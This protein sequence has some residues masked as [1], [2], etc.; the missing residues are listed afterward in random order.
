MDLGR[1]CGR[2]AYDHRTN[3]LNYGQH[4]TT[5]RLSKLHFVSI[6]HRANVFGTT[7]VPTNMPLAPA[8]ATNSISS[9]LA[10]QDR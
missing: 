3:P 4:T 2:A 6:V 8:H 7:T 9:P 10:N 1:R 5:I